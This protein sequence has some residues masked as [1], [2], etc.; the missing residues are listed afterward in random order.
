M[1]GRPLQIEWRD[2]AAGLHRLYRTEAKPDLRPRWHALWLV[3]TGHAARQAARVLG[4]HERT[5][6]QWLAWYR[7]GGVA[8]VRAHRRAGPG[9]PARLTAD[10]QAGLVAQ[11]A[12]GA[13]HTAREAV[14]WVAETFGVRYT[15]WGMYTLF[16]RLG[17]KPKVPRPLGAKASLEAQAAWKG[18]DAPPP[19]GPRA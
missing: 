16:R 2:D 3:R 5:V 19:S 13:F 18:G 15:R 17:C 12:Q 4:V 8:G 1:R 10:Q 6:Q 11:A 9:Q 14:G 7:Q